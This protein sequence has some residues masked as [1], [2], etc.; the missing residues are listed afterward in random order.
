MQWRFR[1]YWQVRQSFRKRKCDPPSWK[2]CDVRSCSFCGIKLLTHHRLVSWRRNAIK[3][4][5]MWESRAE[6]EFARFCFPR[7]V[8]SQKYVSAYNLS[9]V[10]VIT[11][12][13]TDFISWYFLIL[14]GPVLLCKSSHIINCVP[15]PTEWENHGCLHVSSA[16][17][18]KLVS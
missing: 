5:R 14:R 2:A 16:V 8:C 18:N 13:W 9:H 4:W 1:Q 7:F 12:C 17:T 10:L 15:F 3:P 11:H 6:G